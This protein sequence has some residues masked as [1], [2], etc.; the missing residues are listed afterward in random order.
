MFVLVHQTLAQ[1][2]VFTILDREED[3][4]PGKE[5]GGSSRGRGEGRTDGANDS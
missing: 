3:E 1:H 2:Q 5:S 4:V